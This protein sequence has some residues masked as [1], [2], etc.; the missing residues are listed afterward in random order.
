M[1]RISLLYLI[2]YITNL[3]DNDMEVAPKGLRTMEK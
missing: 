2:K 3:S 1:T